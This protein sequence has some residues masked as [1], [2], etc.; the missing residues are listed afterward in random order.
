MARLLARSAESCFWTARYMERAENLARILDVTETFSRDSRG[1]NDW[2]SVVALNADHESLAERYP[3]ATAEAVIHFYVLDGSNPTSILSAVRAAREN[4]R[5]LRP[6]ISTEMWSQINVFYNWMLGLT[7]TDVALHR[8][9]PLLAQIKEGCQAHTG[10]LEGTFYRDEGWYFYQA[11]KMLERADQTTRLLDIKYHTLQPRGDGMTRLIDESQWNAVL[12]AAAGY[13]AFRR[14]HPRGMRVE[15][16][17]GFLLFNDS[18]PRSVAVCIERLDGLLTELKSRYSLRGGN[19]VLEQLDEMRAVLAAK[20]I[21]TVLA[22]GLHEYLDWLQI[23]LNGL[24]GELERS[25]FARDGLQAQG[26][27]AA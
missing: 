24:A 14:I 5:V 9:S 19:S 15:A 4:A 26:Q 27:S 12:R 25:F 21:E 23:R 6:L 1:A 17:A 22:E 20:P 7:P 18:F 8:L 16:V 11:G 3:K 13:H 2:A 10:I